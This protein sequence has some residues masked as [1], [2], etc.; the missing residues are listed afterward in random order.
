MGVAAE[1]LCTRTGAVAVLALTV[2]IPT[3]NESG[4]IESLLRQLG[5]QRGLALEVVVADGGSTDGTPRLALAC[6]AAVV[7]TSPGRGRQ[8]NAGRRAARAPLLLFL[9]ADS[10][11]TAPTQLA[12]AVAA[13]QT[14]QAASTTPL[15]GH[16]Q[17]RFHDAQASAFTYYEG[18]SALGRPQTVN[19]DQGLLIDAHWLDTIG[20]FHETMPFLEDQDLGARIRAVG[21]W[22]LLPGRIE[23]SARRFLV[24]G[25][26]ERSIH[27]AVTMAFFSFRHTP[28][29]ATGRPRYRVQQDSER[30]AVLPLAREIWGFIRHQ[31][32]ILLSLARYVNRHA[33][34]RAAFWLDVRTHGA[35][36]DQTHPWL[37]RYDRWLA[38]WTHNRSGDALCILPT[39]ILFFA[40]W[41]WWAARRSPGVL[42]D[43]PS[44]PPKAQ[45]TAASPPPASADQSKYPSPSWKAADSRPDSTGTRSHH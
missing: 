27:N 14:A 23:T 26:A 17:L 9:H 2:V 18:L 44:G 45:R 3:L 33:L 37:H 43:A 12:D 19:G 13:F 31:P 10:R 5:Q 20:G 36:A 38:P 24:E 8:L 41:G 42:Q 39:L 30:L 22:T 28:F 15:A 29:F 21:G 7:R 35:R 4:H 34:W 25:V 16:F 32:R 6:D 11:L 1:S 40:A